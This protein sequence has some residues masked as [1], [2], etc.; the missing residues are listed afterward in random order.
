MEI[1]ENGPLLFGADRLLEKVVDEI[2]DQEEGM[3]FHQVV[4][5]KFY[6][7]KQNWIKN[8]KRIFQIFNY[9]YVNHNITL[10]LKLGC[11]SR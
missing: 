10:S 5:I 8:F 11:T 3:T 1:K 4:K 9:G 2:Y 7:P 6:K